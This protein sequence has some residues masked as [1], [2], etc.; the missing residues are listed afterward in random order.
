[1][2]S[3]WRSR[4]SSPCLTALADMWRVR[5]EYFNDHWPFLLYG[6]TA[7]A[8][9]NNEPLCRSFCNFWSAEIPVHY[10]SICT[11]ICGMDSRTRLSWTNTSIGRLRWHCVL[12][13]EI[14]S[15]KNKCQRI[16]FA[17]FELSCF[18]QVYKSLSTESEEQNKPVL[19]H[20]IHP[21]TLCNPCSRVWFIRFNGQNNR[22]TD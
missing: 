18:L 10:V 15:A 7:H 12:A 2:W 9:Q 20:S 19:Q 22:K 14:Y 17:T 21:L 5:R 11:Y 16:Y 13:V 1:M 6:L 8:E 4:C 3:S